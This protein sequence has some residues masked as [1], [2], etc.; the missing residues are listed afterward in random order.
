MPMLPNTLRVQT[1]YVLVKSVSPKVLWAES[2]VQGTGAY[3]PPFQLHAKIEEEKIGGVTIYCPF[4]EFHRA[5][6]F[7]KIK[8]VKMS[9]HQRLGDG[10]RLKIVGRLEAGETQNQIYR[11]FSLTPCVMSNIETVSGY[12]INQKKD[13]ARSSISPMDKKISIC[14]L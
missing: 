10:M 1:E 3:F 7:I 12:R 6:G 4:G 5:L 2:R 8:A 14:Q 11:E 9:N 13:W